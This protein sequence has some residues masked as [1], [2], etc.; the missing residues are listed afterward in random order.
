MV[1][2][3]SGTGIEAL[4]VIKAVLIQV[5]DSAAAVDAISKIDV[6]VPITDMGSAADAI[7]ALS[8]L[9]NIIESAGGTD[10]VV[11]FDIGKRIASISFTLKKRKMEFIL[12][13]RSMKFSLN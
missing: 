4:D 1:I 5:A 12:K 10:I 11:R 9:V 2:S 13:K 6:H 3:D 7:G 8:A